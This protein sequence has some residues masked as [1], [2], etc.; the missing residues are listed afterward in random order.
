LATEF[1]RRFAK[2]NNKDVRG[3]SDAA[4]Q[5]LCAYRWPGNVRELENVV[6]QAVVLARQPVIDT[7]DLARRITQVAEGAGLRS[8]KLAAQ[9][10][11]PEKQILINAIRQHGGNIKRTAEM[12]EI[13]RTTLY[14]KLKKYQIDPD[15]IR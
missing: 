1:L 4:M 2:Q 5:A 3:F 15:A 14:G 10:E 6:L 7:A 12:L 8:V 9:L 11:E 13:S